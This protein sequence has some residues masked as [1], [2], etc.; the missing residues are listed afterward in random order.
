MSDIRIS[1]RDHGPAD[2]R[3]FLYE[4][5]FL[6]RGLVELHIEFEQTPK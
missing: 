2:N 6:L 1:E 3:V 4:P 5:T